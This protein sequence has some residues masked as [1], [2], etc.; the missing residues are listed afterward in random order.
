M[1][2][3]LEAFAAKYKEADDKK[4]QEK[5]FN[6]GDIM[7]V[8]LRKGRFPTGTYNK[9]K[10]KKYGPYQIIKKINDNAY[11]VDL[12]ANMAIS[13]TFNVADVLK[14]FPPDEPIYPQPNLRTSSFEVG[15]TDVK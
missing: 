2:N 1:H 3:Q 7:M 11:V 15:G 5:V 8:Y 9:L 10:D 14:Y 13:F 6:E 4:W 12:P